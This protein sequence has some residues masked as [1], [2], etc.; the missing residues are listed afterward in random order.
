MMAAALTCS[1]RLDC[2][3][4]CCTSAFEHT[5]SCYVF[6]TQTYQQYG[7]LAAYAEPELIP[8]VLCLTSLHSGDYFSVIAKG[9]ERRKTIVHAL[10]CQQEWRRFLP[11]ASLLIGRQQ[12][13]RTSCYTTPACR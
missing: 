6:A 10:S 1:S 13:N 4:C 11:Q 9:Q 3:I 2:N 5:D 7:M 12:Q 8:N